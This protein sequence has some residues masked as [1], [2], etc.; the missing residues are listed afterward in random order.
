[1]GFHGVSA[2]SLMYHLMD[3]YRN[4]SA[5]D[6]EECKQALEEPIEVDQPI[7][8]YFQQVKDTKQFD[9]YRKTQFTLVQIVQTE[10]HAVNKTCIYSQA[11]EEWL[12]KAAEDQT[13]TIFNKIAEKAKRKAAFDNNLDPDG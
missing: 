6:L 7:D 8:I 13:W 10:Y 1:M 3:N 9:Q 11:L 2:K 12:K 4:I 5:S